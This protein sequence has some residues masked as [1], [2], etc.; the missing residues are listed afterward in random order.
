MSLQKMETNHSKLR[1]E[2]EQSLEL[3]KILG[4]IW[5]D[6]TEN[7]IFDFAEICSVSKTLDVAKVECF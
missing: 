4:I 6:K 1:K 5:D 3:S 2:G 7:F